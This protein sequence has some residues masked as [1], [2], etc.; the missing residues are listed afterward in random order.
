MLTPCQF[1]DANNARFE[2]PLNITSPPSQ[3]PNPLYD[4]EFVTSPVFGIKVTRVSTGA[5]M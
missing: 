3:A 2:V 1:S 5:V 4:V